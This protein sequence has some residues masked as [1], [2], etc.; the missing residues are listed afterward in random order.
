LSATFG[1]AAVSDGSSP[2]RLFFLLHV[3]LVDADTGDLVHHTVPIYLPLAGRST[4]F[5]MPPHL[6]KTARNCLFISGSGKHTRY[7]WNNDKYMLWEHISKLYYSDL[8]FGLHQL[9][10]LTVEHIQL[11]SYIQ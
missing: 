9:P 8:D 4:S 2:N 1:C 5:L 11:K 3:D 7:L 6:L 10:K